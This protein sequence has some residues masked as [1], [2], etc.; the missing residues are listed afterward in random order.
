LASEQSV[1]GGIFPSALPLAFAVV[2]V[3]IVREAEDG[4]QDTVD[5]AFLLLLDTFR[6][7]Q[8]LVE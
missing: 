5:P 7:I 2:P 3:D 6:E 8:K 1:G 4:R